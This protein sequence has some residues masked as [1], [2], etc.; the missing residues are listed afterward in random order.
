[1]LKWRVILLI[2]AVLFLF[3]GVALAMSPDATMALDRWVMGGGESSRS[4]ASLEMQ[5]TIGQPAIGYTTASALTLYWGYWGPQ[6]YST[7]L[8][9]VLKN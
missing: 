6:P 5:G 3:S 9:L 8:P 4:A 7:Y 1:M 2:L